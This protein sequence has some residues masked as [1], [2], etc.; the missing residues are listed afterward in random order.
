MYSIQPLQKRLSEAPNIRPLA[1][2]SGLSE[3]TIYRVAGGYTS[4]TLKTANQILEALD[5]VYPLAKSKTTKS[6]NSNSVAKNN[7][8]V[9]V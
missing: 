6:K 4:I 8:G 7:T 2:A 1:V 3:K 5:L 9:R